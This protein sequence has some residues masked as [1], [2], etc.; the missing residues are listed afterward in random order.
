MRPVMRGES[1]DDERLAAMSG[2]VS[3]GNVRAWDVWAL[4]LALEK[5][6]LVWRTGSLF[7]AV[8]VHAVY[9]FLITAT[10]LVSYQLPL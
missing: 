1:L 5:A 2:E 4:R 10:V 6:L 7:P 3:S 8:V 9:N